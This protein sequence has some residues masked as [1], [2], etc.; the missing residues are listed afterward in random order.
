ME[1]Y[2]SSILAIVYSDC[3]KLIAS[4]STNNSCHDMVIE[5]P[6]LKN[7]NIFE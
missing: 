3:D 5:V 2:H 4:R 1:K 6:Y 7:E